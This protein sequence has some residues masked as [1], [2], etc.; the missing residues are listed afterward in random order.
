M[1]SATQARKAVQTLALAQRHRQFSSHFGI[2]GIAVLAAPPPPPTSDYGGNAHVFDTS[3]HSNTRIHSQ[4]ASVPQIINVLSP[5]QSSPTASTVTLHSSSGAYTPNYPAPIPIPISQPGESTPDFTPADSSTSPS[6]GGLQRPHLPF[7]LQHNEPQ[8]QEQY[9]VPVTSHSEI[10]RPPLT[11]TDHHQQQ[12]QQQQQMYAT[13]PWDNYGWLFD[14]SFPDQ[15]VMEL[16]QN[17]V[18]YLHPLEAQ[19]YG[20]AGEASSNKGSSGGLTPAFHPMDETMR[21]QVLMLVGD[22]PNL[23]SG[24]VGMAAMQRYLRLYWTEFHPMFPL[25][26]R[27][28][29]VPSIQMV[30]LVAIVLA[31]GA[32]FADPDASNFAM[33]V[34]DKVKGWIL[35]VRDI[36]RQAYDKSV[37]SFSLK[38]F[39]PTVRTSL[40]SSSYS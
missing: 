24:N 33:T 12:H 10:M 22:A 23:H 13:R 2:N 30:M 4:D 15:L 39:L 27:P 3:S 19:H 31:I 7:H 25:L 18:T 40:H 21:S 8:R 37:N 17:Q 38:S 36:F 11:L 1:R 14:D 35:N 20:N 26:H 16:N 9:M 32:S 5:H 6:V 34:Y 29:F 28:T